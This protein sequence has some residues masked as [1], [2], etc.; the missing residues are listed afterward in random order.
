MTWIPP[1]LS[2]VRWAPALSDVCVQYACV[3]VFSYCCGK[4]VVFF[5]HSRRLLKQRAFSVNLSISAATLLTAGWRAGCERWGKL[6]YKHIH[7][8]TRAYAHNVSVAWSALWEVTR[9]PVYVSEFSIRG[10]RWDRGRAALLGRKHCW[11]GLRRCT[12]EGGVFFFLPN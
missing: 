9:V 5:S 1:L 6:R 11:G 8:Y 12:S 4:Q 7:T 3:R 10:H 2:N